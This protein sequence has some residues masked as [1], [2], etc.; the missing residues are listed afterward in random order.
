MFVEYIYIYI[1]KQY[2]PE[3][4]RRNTPKLKY[5]FLIKKNKISTEIKLTT[6]Q[7]MP[8]RPYRACIQIIHAGNSMIFIEYVGIL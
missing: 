8:P 2:N 7:E 6:L 1:Y 5:S 3:T 4:T